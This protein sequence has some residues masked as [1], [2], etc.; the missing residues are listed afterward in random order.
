MTKRKDIL[1]L[2]PKGGR[3]GIYG[4]ERS[5]KIWVSRRK[6]NKPHQFLGKHHTEETKKKMS[7]A[8]LRNAKKYVLGSRKMSEEQKKKLRDFW[9]VNR[10]KH[11][12]WK[13]G[14]SAI[15]SRFR[16]SYEYYLWKVAVKKRDNYTC[17]WCGS[18][19]RPEADHIKSFALFPE[20]RFAIDNGRTLCRNC[21]KTT[22]TYGA[23]SI[24]HKKN[25]K[26]V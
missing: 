10:E 21:H 13:G 14:V 20:L 19:E 17:V 26:I 16:L 24:K 15:Q 25:E 9:K 3:M 2:I 12:N 7:E 4:K 22:D 23:K 1:N 18:K 5:A 11:P 8:R 6:N